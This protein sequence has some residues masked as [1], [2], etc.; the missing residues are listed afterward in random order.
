MWFL[1]RYCGQTAPGQM[2]SA[3]DVIIT[4]NQPVDYMALRLYDF[5]AGL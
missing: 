5:D 4:I 2:A 1:Y 3:N